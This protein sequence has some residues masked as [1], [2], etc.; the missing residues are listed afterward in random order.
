ML[1]LIPRPSPQNHPS[2]RHL[3]YK[4]SIQLP[5]RALAP[6]VSP[7]EASIS[8]TPTLL[9]TH[10]TTT[11]SLHFP[12]SG[13]QSNHL[14]AKQ[15]HFPALNTCLPRGRG[16]LYVLRNDP[17]ALVSTI[18]TAY[19]ETRA[20]GRAHRCHR[21]GSLIE[22]YLSSTARPAPPLHSRGDST[23]AQD[24]MLGWTYSYRIS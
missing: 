20:C 17:V 24:G 8:T 4:F 12:K 11:P 2:R 3:T 18:C 5:H 9:L 13:K 14:V 21:R 16:S 19:P 22:L 7:T 10:C 15:T 23:D 1:I 6:R